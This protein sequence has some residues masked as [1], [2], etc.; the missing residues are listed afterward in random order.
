MRSKKTA[1]GFTAIELIIVVLIICV[2]SAIAFP[3][4]GSQRQ[5]AYNTAAI[6]DLKNVRMT[7][8]AFYD[9]YKSY[10]Y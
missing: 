2:L 8:D 6:S 4:F 1:P 3:F 9:D 7:I 10:P 5:K